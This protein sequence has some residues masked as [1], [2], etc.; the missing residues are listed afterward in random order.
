MLKPADQVKSIHAEMRRIFDA[1]KNGAYLV[2][3]MCR[4]V[5][6]L[7]R[8]LW[9]NKVGCAPD[10]DVIAVGGYGRGELFPY[11]DWDLWILVPEAWQGGEEVEGFLH[12]LWDTKM[13]IGHAVRTVDETMKHVSESWDSA[14]AALES[15]LL[16]GSGC[17]YERL[18][19]EMDRFLKR[20]RAA[21]LK[22]KV[23]E[24]D[25][26]R[27]RAQETAF[28]MEPNIKDG[29]GGLRDVH[30]LQWLGTIAYGCGDVRGLVS[31][32]ALRASEARQIVRATNVLRRVR[33]GLHLV[34]GRCQDRLTFEHQEQLAQALR[35]RKTRHQSEVERW[36][37]LF[38]RQAR[39]IGVNADWFV[40]ELKEAQAA[41]R[42]VPSRRIGAGVVLKGSL[43][44]VEDE[45][46][47]AQDPLNLLRMF[48]LA[49]EGK[50][51]L[52]ARALRLIRDL[53]P[54]HVARIRH[55]EEANALFLEM[56]R[57]PRNV[58]W[59]L[60]EM[61][62]T[63]V[64]GGFIPDFGKAE[65]L[66]Q[67][68]GYHAFTVD[69]HTVKVVAEA[70]ALRLGEKSGEE[71][72]WVGE[73]MAA[74][75]R[76]ELLY[77]AALFHDIGKGRG[78]DHSE[79]GAR[80]AKV[81]CR[82]IGLDDDGTGLVC[83]LVRHHLLMARISQRCDLSDREVVEDFVRKVGDIERLRY[84]AAL[85]VAD[86]RGV[87]PGVWNDWKGSLLQMLY[88]AA[89]NVMMG[90][91]LEGEE[92]EQRMR[93]R[94]KSVLDLAG[95]DRAIQKALAK[96]PKRCLL[97]F[98]PETLHH[99]ACLVATSGGQASFDFVQDR[100]KGVTVLMVLAKDRPRLF[101]ELSAALS[102][103]HV[104]ILAAQ[105]YAIRG[106]WILDVFHLQTR[107]GRPVDAASDLERLRQRLSEVLA[108]K[109]TAV[110]LPRYRASHLMRRVPVRVRTLPLAGSG[111]TALEISCADR[112][113]LLASLALALAD[114]NVEIRGAQISTFG[115]RAVDVFFLTDEQGRPLSD[116]ALREAMAKLKKAAEL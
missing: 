2:G 111:K 58:A 22:A 102:L 18:R 66:G 76:P 81:F 86:I 67:F 83:W 78:G 112:P 104:S 13:A 101:A 46:R 45:D 52:S 49:Q 57:S 94:I 90:K 74:L 5:D 107:G 106:G 6:E 65:G 27:R 50:R 55:R 44:D 53:V 113:G 69:E 87:G 20:K 56:M 43:I 88:K 15:R 1:G 48:H 24:F 103:G 63:G 9:Q 31:V 34:A 42:H 7:I 110:S 70:C 73:I 89:E 8:H 84:L 40:M 97:H 115:A 28:W 11:S 105:A 38:F 39:A 25:A 41:R 85:T 98:P 108:G 3:A 77:L 23:D 64:L 79:I 100:K 10:L 30:A 35:L 14:T 92:I 71:V 21:F 80:L 61:H 114:S 62:E 72:P 12:A 68:D 59:A 51:R 60:K 36:M 54:K 37:R 19:Q 99:I 26:R 93:L 96:L 33:F 29:K 82:R 109:G 32:G 16:I 4:R 116:E 95:H 91:P 75:P 17:Q 47:F